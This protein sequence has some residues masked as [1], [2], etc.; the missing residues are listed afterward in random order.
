MNIVSRAKKLKFED[1]KV[2]IS[3]NRTDKRTNN[4]LQNTIQ[5]GTDRATRT[6]LKN[7]G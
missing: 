6:T 3:K 5:K 4:D 1:T 7:R 2:V